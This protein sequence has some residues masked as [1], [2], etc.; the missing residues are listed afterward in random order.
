M[1][2]KILAF[3]I[4]G[5]LSSSSTVYAADQEPET[6][7]TESQEEVK[8]IDAVQ[9]G[10][11]YDEVV[12]ALGLEGVKT[13]E[14]VVYTWAYTDGSG[15][16]TITTQN[17]IVTAK[18]DVKTSNETCKI[19]L[20]I[21]GQLKTG[22]TYDEVKEIIGSDG[23]LMTETDIGGVKSSMYMWRAEDGI[24]TASIMFQNDIVVSGSQTGLK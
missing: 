20:E 17:G 19:D 11:T 4:I 1:K 6:S 13:S 2:K 16:F 18:N 10:M 9:L 15:Y 7:T 23:T 5:L 21:Y 8:P 24:G 14:T 22:M 3:L 12:K